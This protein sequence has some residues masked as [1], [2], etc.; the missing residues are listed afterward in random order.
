MDGD[1]QPRRLSDKVAIVSGGARGIGAA[2]V[3]AFAAHGAQV[4]AAD[5]DELG[6]R[7]VCAGL[8]D[9]AVGT[10]L[11]VRSAASWSAVVELC[12]Q[13]F[14]APT[15]LVNNA[16]IQPVARF[17]D[18]DEA[19]LRATLDVNLIGVF[20][21]MQ[22]VAGPMA[23]A[24]GG[25]IINLSSVAGL[26]ATS[27]FSAYTASKWGV[28]GLTKAAAVELGSDGIR[29]NSIHP[30]AIDTDMIKDPAIDEILP[31]GGREVRK[32]IA[33]LGQPEEVAMLAVFLASNESSYSTGA[34]FL[35]DGGTMA[36]A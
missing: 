27:G 6:A 18:T 29:V 9:A 3:R 11:D 10:R 32:A 7:Q 24:G 1:A 25:S 35:V 26:K 28:R 33:R 34:E 22:A 8:G 36:G 15:V 5:I 31:P 17:L 4:M 13:T 12:E 23:A 2:I 20:L 19:T 16:G 30:G 14:G 21:G